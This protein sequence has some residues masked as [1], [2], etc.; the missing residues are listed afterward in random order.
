MINI[1]FDAKRFFHNNTGLGNYS[2]DLIRILNQ[3]YPENNYFLYNPKKSKNKVFK[4]NNTNVFEK[5]PQSFFFKK[6]KN[7]WRQ[8]GIVQDLV[9][10][11]VTLFH[12]MS[13]ELPIGL[14]R[15]NIKSI[16]TIHDLIFIRYPN[17]Y[18]FFDRKIH[19]LKFKKAA[20]NADKIIA[21]SE[22]TKKDIVSFFKIEP[23]KIEVIY[24]G[25]QSV[26]KQ[27]YSELEKQSV[28]N[29]FH[30]PK[31]FVL[32]VGT[33]E[34]RKNAL[35]IVKAIKN[36][37]TKLVL[38]GKKTK[39]AL[40][41]EEYITTHNLQ[42]KVIFLNGISSQELAIIYQLATVFV[43][44]SLFEGFGIP[45]IEALYSKTPVI[46]SKDGVFPEAGGPNSIYI[47]PYNAEELQEKIQILLK[48][49]DLRNEM[50]TK[51]YEFAQRF[52]DDVIAKKI[53]DCYKS[54]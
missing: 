13:G 22:Q 30:L 3:H 15:N 34:K 17:L 2:R 47:D 35:L 6:F 52:N 8:K 40:I 29:K 42:D 37:N 27:T 45:I 4:T 7:Y 19:Y 38:I 43:Y 51:G 31:E 5:L 12:G 14:K 24:Q 23:E 16:V 54:L 50:S 46:T 33:I 10:D 48:N 9:K 20:I 49:G 53:I 18:S 41:I 21:I 26:F 36:C 11:E 32:N 28:A 44:P 39:Y 1:G 25:C